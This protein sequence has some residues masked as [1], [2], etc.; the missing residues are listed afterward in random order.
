MMPLKLPEQERGEKRSHDVL[1]Y[2]KF[3]EL[4]AKRKT[5]EN[6]SRSVKR[7]EFAGG[8]TVFI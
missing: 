1:L 6:F 5:Q 4:S 7:L 3:K 8:N 2:L